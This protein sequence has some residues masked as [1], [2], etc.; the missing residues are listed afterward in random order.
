MQTLTTLRGLDAD[1]N[2]IVLQ[3]LQDTNLVSAQDPIV[4]LKNSDL[5][6][7][8]LSGVNLSDMDLTSATLTGA[9]LNGADLYGADLEYADL[10]DAD[11]SD[12]N[13]SSAT[14][15]SAFLGST[16]M[17]NTILTRAH[18]N[19]AI[20]TGAHLNGAHLSGADLNGALLTNTDLSNTDL[21]DADLVTGSLTQPQLDT[22]QS[23]TNTALPTTLTCHHITTITLQYWYTETTGGKT[24]EAHVIL[25]LINQ[26]NEQ[27]RKFHIHVNPVPMNYYQTETAFENAAKED[28]APDVLRSD[29]SWVAQ[30]ASQG[31]LLNLDSYTPQSYLSGYLSTPLSYDYYNNHLYGLP[32]VTDFLAL[33]Y[34]KAELK[35]AHASLPSAMS[36]FTMTDFE[37]D[38][39]EVVHSGAA[40]Y[41]FETDGSGYNVLPFLY[42]FGGGMLGKN[43]ILVNDRGSVAGLS[44]LLGLQ[45]AG[46][47]PANVNYS[48]GPTTNIVYDFMTGKTA[49][50]FGGPYNVPQILAGSR[51]VFKNNNN[52]LGI[53]GIPTC[54]S[55]DWPKWLEGPPTCHAG[56][57]RTPSGGQSY[58]IYA[59][60][61]HPNEADEFISFMS[62]TQ[63]QVAI[64]EANHTLPTRKPAYQNVSGGQFISEFLPIA[65]TA[66]AQP[67]VPQGGSGHL[68]DALTPGIADALDG[69]ES[70]TAAL[71]SVANA[72]RQLLA[73]S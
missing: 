68:F 15:T 26:F 20:L 66:V 61:L 38:A 32:Q 19:G 22:V 8:D 53:A 42:T 5:S 2:K 36:D 25:T 44:F 52:N 67:A 58:V 33:L 49:M 17:N 12:A 50:I 29:V 13:L 47:M 72:W 23:C 56:Y 45:Q 11:L 73:G 64:A 51:S 18:L 16:V 62:K 9:H 31:Y 39:K 57:S 65:P 48:N 14:L 1:R 40:S 10:S 34:N 21:S 27:Y 71:N 6:N 37:R 24:A 54:P 70:P 41:G 55:A 59:D 43:N 35:E 69:V 30:F 46:L 3:F 4:N 63:Q 7:A 60:T 28:K